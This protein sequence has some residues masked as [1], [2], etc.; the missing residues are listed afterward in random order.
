MFTSFHCILTLFPYKTSFCPHTTSAYNRL[1][2][3]S[4]A[5][6]FYILFNFMLHYGCDDCFC[7]RL[8][9]ITDIRTT[10][11]KM[12]KINREITSILVKRKIILQIWVHNVTIHDFYHHIHTQEGPWRDLYF[13][14]LF[15]LFLHTCYIYMYVFS[16][17]LS[18]ENLCG[19]RPF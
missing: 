8:Q 5:P 11:N 17:S 9:P 4:I 15:I 13:L 7:S 16:L 6:I 18:S 10:S 19:I 12:T 3:S 14:N 1:F 2:Q